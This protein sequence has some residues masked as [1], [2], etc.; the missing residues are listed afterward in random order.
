MCKENLTHF[1]PATYKKPI[2]GTGEPP[3]LNHGYV[4][5]LSIVSSIVLS[6]NCVS[7]WLPFCSIVGNAEPRMLPV[8]VDVGN[9]TAESCKVVAFA[10]CIFMLSSVWCCSIT[11]NPQDIGTRDACEVSVTAAMNMH[12]NAAITSL[13]TIYYPPHDKRYFS[14]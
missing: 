14:A 4:N 5:V 8:A 1:N 3:M 13:F 7:S 2:D 9:E 10:N 11:G 6:D 12:K